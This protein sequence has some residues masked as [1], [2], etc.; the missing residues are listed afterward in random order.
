MPLGDILTVNI[1]L[2]AAAIPRNAFGTSLMLHLLTDAQNTAFGTD[3]TTLLTLA[4]W[5]ATLASFGIVSGEPAYNDV[6]SHFGQLRTPEE[7]YLG[8]QGIAAESLLITVP[9]PFQTWDIDIPAVPTD[10][11][12]DVIVPGE[13][14]TPFKFTASSSTQQDVVDGLIAQFVAGSVVSFAWNDAGSGKIELTAIVAGVDLS[15]SVA[16]TGS[17]ATETQVH[18]ALDGVYD[19]VVPG[20]ANTPFTFTASTSTGAEI[21]TGLLIQ[22]NAGD[23]QTLTFADTSAGN[24]TSITLQ[25]IAFETTLGASVVSPSSLMTLTDTDANIVNR[26]QV[27]KITFV[28]SPNVVDGTYTMTVSTST[29]QKTY[30]HVASSQTPTVVATAMKVLYDA[31]PS[32][33]TTTT[34]TVLAGVLTLTAATSGVPYSVTIAS[35][36]SDATSVVF[37][38]NRDAG[39]DVQR[40]FDL[41]KNW[42]ML[43]PG[44]HIKNELLAMSKTIEGLSQGRAMI[45]QTSDADIRTSATDDLLS[46]LTALQRERTNSVEHPTDAEGVHTGWAGYY[47]TFPV[48]KI[49]PKGRTV[50]GIIGQTFTSSAEAK[51]IADKNGSYLELFP[52]RGDS[53]MLG[54]GFSATGRPIEVIRILD[55]VT[56]DINVAVFEAVVTPD[57]VLYSEEGI[58]I[59]TAAIEGVFNNAVDAGYAAVGSL[60][61]TP[62]K[63]EDAT[64]IQEQEGELPPYVFS[65]KIVIGIHK[66]TVNGTLF[67]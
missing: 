3:F 38:S 21:V 55:K 47:L 65:F 24:V 2:G 34:A 27:S 43:L 20:E 60:I 62:P 10:E 17:T 64:A 5:P 4:G 44:S 6:Q 49:T 26:A 14:N 57:I 8:R 50:T 53:I 45:L 35:P 41:N 33:L 42:Y 66:T 18:T 52:A 30:V 61:L 58:K 15:V 63:I 13:A 29:G 54:S 23:V 12:Y 16:G 28:G 19:I 59:G 11:D 9:N 1:Q 7:A 40:A 51:F 31:D 46:T 48:G 25:Q 36:N 56:D 37:I 32:D 22:L 67:Q 39:D